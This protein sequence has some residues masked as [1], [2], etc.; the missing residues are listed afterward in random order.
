MS[1][2]ARA[3]YRSPWLSGTKV[4]GMDASEAYLEGARRHRAHANVA[5]EHGDACHL[6]YPTASFDACVSTLAI[7]LIP[8]VDQVA[9][10]MRR[11]TRPGGIVACGQFD[12][13][14]GFFCRS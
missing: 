11:V 14:G 6:R 5:Y 9:A 7:D 8:D 13:W 3:P 4:V 12:N 10:E 2:A 1:A